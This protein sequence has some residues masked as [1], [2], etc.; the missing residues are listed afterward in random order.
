MSRD[1]VTKYFE[2]RLYSLAMVAIMIF[3]LCMFLFFLF[4][5]RGQYVYAV[6]IAGA[7]VLM[8]VGAIKLTQYARIFKKKR[9]QEGRDDNHISS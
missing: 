3:I 4:M 9:P 2:V 7:M 5:L 6:I 1:E 8:V